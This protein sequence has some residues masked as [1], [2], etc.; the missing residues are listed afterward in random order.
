MARFQ[1]RPA[2]T[3]L[4][5]ELQRDIKAFFVSYRAA[6][7]AADGL[8]FSIGRPGVLDGLCQSSGIGKLTPAALYIHESALDLLAPEL[9]LF[10]GC[11]RNYVGRIEGANLIK[12][13]RAEPKVSYLSYPDFED[14]PHPALCFSVTVHLQTFRE[15]YRDFRAS[16]N[17]PILHR[18]DT[19]LAPDHP[20]H[21]K[22]SR[23][24]RIEEQ[25]GLFA[26]TRV[27]GTREGW[28]AV[29][30]AAGVCFK[31]HRLLSA[32]RS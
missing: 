9:R 5:P 14:D 31:G 25:K 21:S 32:T 24:T 30:A 19:F 13:H 16:A 7:N 11:A 22:F 3:Q 2:Y 20:L 15:K 23:L 18:K 4:P 1:Q 26:D 27:I 12:L 8:L 29:L 10:E 17:P 6:C 28:C